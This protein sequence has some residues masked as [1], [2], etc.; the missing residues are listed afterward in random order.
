M[1]FFPPLGFIEV[2]PFIKN[3]F[4]SYIYQFIIF[5]EFSLPSFGHLLSLICTFIC[6]VAHQTACYMEFDCPHP[7]LPLSVRATFSSSF[8][9]QM[10]N[11]Y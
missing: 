7:F 11:M 6:T 9:S 8:E 3:T 10:I 4:P 5:M 2:A 1:I